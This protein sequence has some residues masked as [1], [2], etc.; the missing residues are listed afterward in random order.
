MASIILYAL[1]TER[2]ISSIERRNTLTL[3]V[4]RT[5]TK[6]QIKQEVE[7]QFN[8]KVSAV[9]TLITP[10]GKKKAFVRFAKAGEAADVASKLKII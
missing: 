6:K 1:S 3:V 10:T 5:A 9:S 7:K 2:A 8:A 4:S